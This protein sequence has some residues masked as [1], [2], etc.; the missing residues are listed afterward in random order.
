M[1][2]HHKLRESVTQTEIYVDYDTNHEDLAI[3][4][5]LRTVGW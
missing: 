1:P 3:Y 4:H 2:V 5:H